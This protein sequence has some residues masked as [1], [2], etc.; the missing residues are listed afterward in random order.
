M[1]EEEKELQIKLA[2]LQTDVQTSLAFG[3][4]Y[5]AVSG[6][7]LIASIQLMLTSVASNFEL[8]KNVGVGATFLLFVALLIAGLSKINETEKYR[9]E[10]NKL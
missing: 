3:L 10:M 7:L 2:K 1:D 6:G 8:L 4:A 5:F 9:K